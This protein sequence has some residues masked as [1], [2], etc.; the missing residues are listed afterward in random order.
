MEFL[1]KSKTYWIHCFTNF[2]FTEGM[3]ASLYVEF[4]NA[5]LKHLYNSNVS[6]CNL[7]K[8][9]HRLLDIQDKE[10][11]Y[12]FWQLAIPSIKNQIKTNFLFTKIDHCLQKFF[13]PTML[14]MH[15]DEIDKSLYYNT[16]S[17]VENNDEV[18]ELLN[19]L[20]N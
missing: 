9:I 18:S 7:A 3:I 17:L 11:K 2:K 10:N 8:E 19:C 6:L 4:V 20:F 5:Y 16:A 14:K 1:Y 13:T 12:R 15:R